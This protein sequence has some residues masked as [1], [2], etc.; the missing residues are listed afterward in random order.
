[1]ESVEERWDGGGA[2]GGVVG[3]GMKI[4]GFA[5][6]E[7]GMHFVAQRK[8]VDDLVGRDG[9][10]CGRKIRALMIELSH[11]PQHGSQAGSFN[12]GDFRQASTEKGKGG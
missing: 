6:G 1:M 4:E 3:R 2:R 9:W 12:F 5:E 7:S 8:P 11:R 10:E